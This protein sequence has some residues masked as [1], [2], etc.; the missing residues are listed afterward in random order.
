MLG[1]IRDETLNREGELFEEEDLFREGV[2]FRESDLFREG[3]PP[4][5]PA[6]VN[7]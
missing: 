3:E 2:L 5:E 1:V 4:G 7:T 6:F